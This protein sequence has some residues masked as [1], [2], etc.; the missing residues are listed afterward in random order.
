MLHDSTQQTTLVRDHLR[1]LHSA[2]V[3]TYANGQL[4]AESVAL[5]IPSGLAGKAV[6]GTAAALAGALGAV[7]APANGDP[8]GLGAVGYTCAGGKVTWGLVRCA[9]S[10]GLPRQ[11]AVTPDALGRARP[12]PWQRLQPR[13]PPPQV[14][15]QEAT[16]PQG[17]NGREP[18]ALAAAGRQPRRPTP[19]Y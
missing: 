3:A 2:R 8:G 19:I 15:Q 5:Y 9:E 4:Q 18:A 12:P 10:L 11:Q 17:S 14:P 7:P 13:R 16:A 1:R 6:Q